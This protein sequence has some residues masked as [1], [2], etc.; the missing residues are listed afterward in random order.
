[1]GCVLSLVDQLWSLAVLLDKGGAMHGADLGS[2]ASEMMKARA[3]SLVWIPA[4]SCP[5]LAYP[6]KYELCVQ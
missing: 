2:A 3:Y 6:C 4:A 1:M 5:G